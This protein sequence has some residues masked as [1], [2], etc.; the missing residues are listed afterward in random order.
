MKTVRILSI[1]LCLNALVA[2]A[3]ELDIT[4]FPKMQEAETLLYQGVGSDTPAARQV[5]RVLQGIINRETAEVFLDAGGNDT[6]WFKYIAKPYH[7]A[8]KR[9]TSG[10]NPALRT[11]FGEY[12]DRIDKLVVCEFATASYT[13]NMGV[14]M[15]CVENALPVSEEIK[16]LLLSEFPDW[17]GDVVDIRQNWSSTKAAYEWAIKEML[18]KMNKRLLFSAGMRNDWENGEWKIYDYAVATRSFTFFLDNHTTEGADLIRRII[19]EG[20]YE[21]NATC[22]GYGMHGDDLNDTMNPEG[23]GYVVGDFIP[24]VSFYSSLPSKRFEKTTPKGV[25][26]EDDKVYVALHFSDGDN[27]FFDHNLG[28]SIFQSSERGK[29][30]V[31]M[32]LAPALTE[33]APFIL[34]YYH[35]NVTENDE[36]IGGPSGF[37]YIQESFYKTTDYDEWCRKNNLWLGQAGMNLTASS[38]KWPAQPSLN[39]SFVKA[40]PA[41]TLAWTSGAYYPAYEWFGMP[42][43]GT[44][45]VCTDMNGMYKYLSGLNPDGAP[46]FTGIYMVQ[47]GFGTGAYEAANK[48]KDKLEAEFP[49]KYVFLRASDLMETAKTYF[50]SKRSA[51]KSISIPGILEIEDFDNGGRWIAY[52][53]VEGSYSSTYR[54]DAPEVNIKRGQSGYYVVSS[55]NEWLSYTVDVAE[56]GAYALDLSMYV[57]NDGSVLSVVMDGEVLTTIDTASSSAFEDFTTMVNIPTTGKHEIRL[58]FYQAGVRIDYLKFTKTD[59]VPVDFTR[60]DCFRIVAKHSGKALCPIKTPESGTN[61]VQKTSNDDASLWRVLESVNGYY[62]MKPID[63][64]LYMTCRSGKRV[65]MFDWDNT[66]TLQHWNIQYVDNDYF[67]ICS[68][69]TGKVIEVSNSSTDE[70]ASLII[71]ERTCADNQLFRFQKTASGIKDIAPAT[72]FKVKSLYNIA[73]QRV[74]DSYCGIVISNGRKFIKRN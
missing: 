7:R 28:L 41:G 16:D 55:D 44:G 64:D 23:I 2:R 68:R 34:Q 61:V 17:Q 33:L 11:L 43:V 40:S 29:T 71:A 49:G 9:Y 35:D 13:W 27:I 60:D 70:N 63:S 19:R 67:T 38:L 56:A 66:A 58:C 22:M 8:A 48:L 21:L 12:K 73:G 6:F 10:V 42:V 39:N 59:K 36:L 54:K 52:G 25:T 53:N 69:G 4:N 46:I 26:P 45:A 72:S 3:Q 37:Q 24:N 14:L 20:H 50:A 74:D 18:P 62:A 1:L 47:A 5:M 15:A 30:P 65:Q 32:T 31:S 51:Y 57:P